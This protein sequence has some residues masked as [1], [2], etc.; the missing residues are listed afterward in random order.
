M[1]RNTGEA[2]HSAWDD[3]LKRAVRW[4]M[5]TFTGEATSSTKSPS[6]KISTAATSI[7]FETVSP[8]SFETSSELGFIVDGSVDIIT[9]LTVDDLSLLGLSWNEALDGFA[10]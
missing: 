4:V 8:L 7:C 9:W 3:T 6:D 10:T 5:P 2:I 1:A